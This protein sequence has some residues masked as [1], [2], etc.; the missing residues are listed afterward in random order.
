VRKVTNTCDWI[1]FYVLTLPLNNR[2][3]GEITLEGLQVNL[4]IVAS[5]MM[6]TLIFKV[7]RYCNQEVNGS[8][9]R[10]SQQKYCGF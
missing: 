4:A 6:I 2:T 3:C 7:R 1:I 9:G 8:V 10:R 5:K